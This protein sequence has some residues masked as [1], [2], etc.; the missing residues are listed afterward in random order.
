MRKLRLI[1]TLAL[2]IKHL[3]PAQITVACAANVRFAMEDIKSAF[4]KES[5]ATVTTIYGASGMLTSQIKNGAPFDLFVSADMSYPESLY[6]WHYAIDKPQTYAYGKLVI[7]S[8]KGLEPDP[9]LTCLKNGSILKIGI[10]DPKTAPY[11]REAV[12]AMKRAGIYE[13]L[14]PKLVFG[15]NILQTAQYIRM[16]LVEIGFNSKAVAS[17][18]PMKGVGTWVDVDSSLC[19]PIAQ[20]VVELRYGKDNNPELAEKFYAF[21]FGNESRS[22]LLKFGYLLP[23]GG[24]GDR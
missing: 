11:G 13:Q 21:L 16:G 3:A 4:E 5:G 8:A 10:P 12:K 1:L 9:L 22:V 19:D 7:W 14:L 15:E 18:G 24:N 23:G 6:V 20:G 2:L 17:A